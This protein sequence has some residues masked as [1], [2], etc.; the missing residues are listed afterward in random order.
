MAKTL[1]QMKVSK[2]LS[3]MDRDRTELEITDQHGLVS[4]HGLQGYGLDHDHPLRTYVCPTSYMRETKFSVYDFLKSLYATETTGN[5]RRHSSP[6]WEYI[7]PIFR[8]SQ[9]GNFE[10]YFEGFP[11]ID[12]VE[13]IVRPI[14]RR[15]VSMDMHVTIYINAS[16]SIR[17]M[18]RSKNTHQAFYSL[19]EKGFVDKDD[20]KDDDTWIE[21]S[22]SLSKEIPLAEITQETL[23]VYRKILAKEEDR[24]L[25]CPPNVVMLSYLNADAHD[26]FLGKKALNEYIDEIVGNESTLKLF[27]QE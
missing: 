24:P 25:N 5:A 22:L 4:I 14:I 21:L 7:I 16:L 1:F 13:V 18:P 15:M 19:L 26:V 12:A 6:N 10:K 3:L 8:I 23:E 17:V 9:E 11:G 27:M 20:I 2:F